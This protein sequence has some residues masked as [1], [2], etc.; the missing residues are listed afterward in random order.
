MSRQKPTRAPER[1]HRI[2]QARKRK[3][4]TQQQLADAL[5]VNRVSIARVE[6]GTRSPSMILALR[7]SEVLGESVEALFGGAR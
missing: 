3:G 5:G 4:L 2:A 7:L 1:G 6:A